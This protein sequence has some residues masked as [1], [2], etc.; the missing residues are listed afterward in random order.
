VRPREAPFDLGG[1]E[2][3]IGHVF[4]DRALLE[5][6][7]THSSCAH[8]DVTGSLRDNEPLE[9]LGDA[10]LSFVVADHLHRLDPEAP[11]GDKTRI[12]NS[13]VSSASLARCAEVLGLPLL[14][15]LGRGEEKT[16]GRRKRAL[17]A[18][19]LE[20]VVAA[21]YLDGGI[22]PVRRL[23]ATELATASHLEGARRADPKTELQELLQ[24][25]G[26]PPPDYT[27]L[28][29]DGPSHRPR[30]RIACVVDGRSL[31][32]G[33]GTTKKKAQQEAARGALQ[34]LFGGFVGGPRP[35]N[36]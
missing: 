2:E 29:E 19:A 11:E 24:D 8:E 15:R 35:L 12:R 13:L 7:L 28:S 17:W 6:A 31:A 21:V 32:V 30:F 16:G 22:D 3:R 10:V 20:A 18:D 36:P 25:R 23:V 33:A 4:A 1:L 9:F 5:R 27:V 26:Q 14:L 34:A